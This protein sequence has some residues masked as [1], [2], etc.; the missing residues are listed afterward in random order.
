LQ[1]LSRRLADSPLYLAQI[2]VGDPLPIGEPAQRE[3]GPLPLLADELP[4]FDSR[5]LL[6]GHVNIIQ[7]SANYCKHFG[8]ISGPVVLGCGLR[9]NCWERKRVSMIIEIGRA[10]CRERGETPGGIG[11]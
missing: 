7:Q 9:A 5:A 2:R 11:S 1:D 10:S 6:F 8:P 3:V 4:E